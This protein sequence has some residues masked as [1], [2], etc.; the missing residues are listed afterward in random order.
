MDT[1]LQDKLYAKYPLLF[2]QK[3]W[4]KTKTAMCW[5]I[6]VGDGWYNIIDTVCTEIQELIDD[7]LHTI[8]MFE[9]YLR[10]NPAHENASYF[11]ESIANARGKVIPQ[12]QICQIKEKWGSLCIYLTYYNPQINS[13]LSFASAMS[14]KTCE[15][16]GSPG[17]ASKRGWIYVMCDPCREAMLQR[18][19]E[20]SVDLHQLKLPFDS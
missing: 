8:E 3:D 12:V 16:C 15:Q 18:T 5:G 20:Q 4:D 13:I 10:E 1:E 7:P 17:E 14:L 6:G 9:K 11:K 19:N 2:V